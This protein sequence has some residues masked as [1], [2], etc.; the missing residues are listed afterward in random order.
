MSNLSFTSS[1]A[2]RIL[3]VVRGGLKPAGIDAHVTRSWYRCMKEYGIEPTAK[4]ESV[5]LDPQ[6]G[7]ARDPVHLQ[8]APGA[9][10][11]RTAAHPWGRMRKSTGGAWSSPHPQYKTSAIPTIRQPKDARRGS[12]A[13]KDC[14]ASHESGR[15]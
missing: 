15:R 13:E 3:N 10:H 1:H 7:R 14:I 9:I 5:V 8:F 6:T 11:M 12:R 2:S 4:R